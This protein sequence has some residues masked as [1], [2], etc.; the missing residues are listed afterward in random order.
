[1]KW[2][3]V[4]SFCCLFLTS[5]SQSRFKYS[6]HWY[7][8]NVVLESGDTVP[9]KVRYNTSLPE[10]VVQVLDGKHTR[11]LSIKDVK[12]F[13][14]QDESR[15]RYRTFRR[16]EI[17]EGEFAGKFFFCELLYKNQRFSILKH[18]TLGTP[19]EHMRY[20][21]F[22]KKHSVVSQRYILDEPTGKLFPLSRQHAMSLM[23]EKRTEVSSFI[24]S[25]DIKF[26]S[27]TDYARVFDY[28][29]SL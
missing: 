18:R 7:N 4:I 1:M 11:S 2:L 14:Y 10:S 22:I 20:S 26:K 13:S 24:D 29:A 23:N 9:C 25:H 15:N 12:A 16:L 5:N 21:W 27:L 28:H 6:L 19:Y 17:M 8:G 3:L